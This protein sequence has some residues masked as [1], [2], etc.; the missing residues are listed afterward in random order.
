MYWIQDDQFLQ[1]IISY[2][3]VST[4]KKANP[5]ENYV[6]WLQGLERTRKR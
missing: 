6:K 4:E 2:V 3:C 5:S 1:V